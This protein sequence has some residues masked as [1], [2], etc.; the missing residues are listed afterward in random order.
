M[1]AVV[2]V[3]GRALGGSSRLAVTRP[4]RLEA[5]LAAMRARLAEV[6]QAYSRFRPDS[7]LSAV[8]DR[9]GEL[10]RVSPQ[11][12]AAVAA[13]LRAARLSGGAVDPT[14]GRVM[15]V[16]GYD[17]TFGQVAAHGPAIS[18][19]PR[20]VAGWEAI[21]F[22]PVAHTL[23]LP[24]GVELDLGATG[25]GLAADLA[26]AAA[27]AASGTGAGVLVSLGGDIATAG[28]APDGGWVI[29]VSEDSGAPISA[30]AEAVSIRSGALAT[31]SITVRHWE[32]GE[33]QLHHIL[34]PATGL[35]AAGPWRTASAIAAT[36]VDANL[37][38][39]GA[40]VK[41]EGAVEWLGQLNLPA[42]LVE[43]Q[44]RI[45]RLGGWPEVM[46]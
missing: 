38:S 22:D 14:L 13:G 46:A 27:L 4:D 2:V 29:Q 20:S 7:E 43:R 33:V 40:I 19:R 36:C 44:G 37:A 11:L 21:Q 35:P 32:R 6:D 9:P 34:D 30:G 41:G 10:H 18:L 26:A 45:T 23:R 42:R 1:T 5:A 39:T 31:S 15:R 12:A 17:R 8:N 24:E 3:D 25:K 28:I 16:V